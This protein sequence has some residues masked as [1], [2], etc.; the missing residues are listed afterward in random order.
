MA[1]VTAIMLGGKRAGK[2]SVLAGVISS[3]N[4]SFFSKYICTGDD[5][6]YSTFPPDCGSV[7]DKRIKLE[8]FIETQQSN[9]Y[10]TV[11]MMADDHI[12]C[13]DLYVK[14]PGRSG[15]L[16]MRF[17]DVPGEA[18]KKTHLLNAEVKQKI[19][20]AD[21]F[22]IAVDTPFLMQEKRAINLCCNRI[23]DV[24]DL[25]SDMTQ[26]GEL[27]SKL[28]LF[29][30][31][32]C[33]YWALNNQIYEVT[34][35]VKSEYAV[36]LDDLKT[37]NSLGIMIMPIQTAGGIVFDHTKEA[38]KVVKTNDPNAAVNYGSLLSDKIL[39][40]RNGD[41]CPVKSGYEVVKYNNQ[42]VYHS[43][44]PIPF[45]WYK[46]IDNGKG[47]APEHCEQPAL[48]IL[49]FLIYKTVQNKRAT[50][51]WKQFWNWWDKIWHGLDYA[52]FESTIQVMDR[53]GLIRSEGD[54]FEIIKKLY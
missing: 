25:L 23:D 17:Y 41:L 20:E 36:L 31:I 47:Y 27:D 15:K 49:K 42:A 43:P 39:R 32:K 52:A 7:A 16:T 6:D 50:T 8:N 24:K 38:M 2:S 11:D 13:Y 18:M 12:V 14:L 9:R 1:T 22:I 53:D 34:E 48:H 5:T 29:V 19:S 51:V 54:G 40:L 28:V 37:R 30:P 3:L 35:K 21:I 10:F 46:V 26:S 4:S 33:E 44:I 45:V